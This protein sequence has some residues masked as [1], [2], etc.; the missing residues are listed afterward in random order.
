MRAASIRAVSVSGAVAPVEARVPLAAVVSP[1]ASLLLHPSIT[2]TYNTFAYHASDR[3]MSHRVGVEIRR[4]D[5]VRRSRMY[6]YPS[7]AS[8]VAA[9]PRSNARPIVRSGITDAS[10]TNTPS[11][12]APAYRR[13]PVSAASYTKRA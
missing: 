5:D 2:L 11:G 1:S 7:R 3:V 12:P 4:T 10:I 6:V 13:S 9:K 8:R